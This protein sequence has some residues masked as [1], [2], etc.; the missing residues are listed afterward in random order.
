MDVLVRSQQP[1]CF[2]P[3]ISKTKNSPSS[4]EV[5][6][7]TIA[8]HCRESNPT[9]CHRIHSKFH[10]DINFY[11]SVLN[12]YIELKLVLIASQVQPKQ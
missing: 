8:I 3:D 4:S 9:L 2:T 6:M 1:S 12:S 11:L 10:D 5:V 7:N